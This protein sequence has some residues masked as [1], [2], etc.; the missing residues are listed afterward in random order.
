MSPLFERQILEHRHSVQN[1]SVERVESNF[2][3][4][5]VL[6]VCSVTCRVHAVLIAGIV[7]LVEGNRDTR[8]N[9]LLLRVAVW[10][11]LTPEGK[12]AVRLGAA[13][14]VGSA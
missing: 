5:P 7:L 11:A 13:Q 9:D 6:V 3:P 8:L 2:A 14:S 1:R 12:A 4:H 10:V